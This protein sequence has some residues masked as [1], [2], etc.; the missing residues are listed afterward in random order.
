MAAL[1]EKR[2]MVMKELRVGSVGKLMESVTRNNR[3]KVKT[4]KSSSKLELDAMDAALSK[5]L[6]DQQTT[7][8]Q[9][10]QL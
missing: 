2:S 6:S 9:L 4:L 10:L 8:E 5:I 1:R 7:H 3:L